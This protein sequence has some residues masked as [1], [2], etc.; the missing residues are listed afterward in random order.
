[1][2]PDPTFE[3]RHST[4]LLSSGSGCAALSRVV[5]GAIATATL[6]LPITAVGHD[7]RVGETV[8]VVADE[9]I[10]NLQGKRLVSLIVDYAPGAESVPHRHAGSA[11]IYA[12]VVSGTIRSQVDDERVR[13]FRAGEG[14]FESPG[15]H[16]R[17]SANASA[18]EPARLL[19]VFIVDATEQ[20]LTTPLPPHRDDKAATAQTSRS[21]KRP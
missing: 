14:W 12:F 13:V 18:T 4:S 20:D 21:G 1:M 16:H 2:S 19:A 7:T 6:V 17:I 8:A 15:A 9:P 5:V 3:K 10:P 11:F